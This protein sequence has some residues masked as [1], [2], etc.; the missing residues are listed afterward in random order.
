[1]SSHLFGKTVLGLTNRFPRANEAFRTAL[2]AIPFYHSRGFQKI[3]HATDS[4]MALMDRSVKNLRSVGVKKPLALGLDTSLAQVALSLNRRNPDAY[5]TKSDFYERHP[6]PD[7]LDRLPADSKPAVWWNLRYKNRWL[8]DGSV[9]S[10][11]PVFTNI[12]WNEVGRGADLQEIDAWLDQNPRIIEE[13][14]T[15]V[16]SAEAPPMTDFFDAEEFDLPRAQEGQKLFNTTCAR[17]HGT[18]EKAWDRADASSLSKKELLKTTMVR[19]HQKTPVIDVGTDPLRHQGMTSLEKLNDLVVSQKQ[20]TV[21]RPQKGYVPPPLVGIWA[22]W[23][24]FHNNS[25]P[26]LCAV[27]TRGPERPVVYYSGEAKDPKTDFDQDCNGYPLGAKTPAAWKT[28]EHRYD[29][30]TKGM[31]RFGHDEGV[32]LKNDR[33]LFTPDQKKSIIRFLQTL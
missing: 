16:F 2:F 6:R 17:C 11:N 3:T 13:L 33:E 30:R 23:P 15:A 1:H 8:S 28:R 19:Y 21:I 20:G 22:R 9:V 12:L 7:R 26:S 18:Y 25:A 27:L 4:E 14:T 10:G 32:F 29:T 5:A 24:Y 31:S